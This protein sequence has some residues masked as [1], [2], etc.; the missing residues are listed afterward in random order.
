[1]ILTVIVPHC[2]G[3]SLASEVR[4]R[5]IFDERMLTGPPA[6]MFG[7]EDVLN[8]ADECIAAGEQ[9]GW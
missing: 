2:V 4:T 9:G 6:A 8:V 5:L 7:L 1:M 3:R